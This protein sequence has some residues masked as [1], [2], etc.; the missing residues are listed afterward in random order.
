MISLFLAI[1][2]VIVLVPFSV[3]G[4]ASPANGD[5]G[6]VRVSGSTTLLSLIQEASV[7]FNE[8]NPDVR[9]DVQGG[10]SSAGIT[11]LR[12]GIVDI[13]NSSRDLGE[14]ELSEGFV[15]H[16][17][18]FDIIQVV[19]NPANPVSNLSPEQLRRIYTG[20]IRNWRAVGGRN[21][22]IVLIVRD[23]A[24][25]T[26]EVFDEEGLG[27]T[28]DK[29]VIS[30]ASAIEGTSNGFVQEVV[31]TT[32]NAI[33]YLSF[34]FS[35][36]GSGVKTLKIDGVEPSIKNAL[37]GDYGVA[38]WLYM[39]TKGEATGPTADFIDFV[40][41]EAFQQDVLSQEYVTI[42]EAEGR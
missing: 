34:G 17:I 12:S 24:S 22:E 15:G 7:R 36:K 11:Q 38:R 14:N 23:H 35:K 32:P 9:V 16:N 10:G 26:R 3:H 39:F 25:G 42:G 2:L 28:A 27:S 19:V 40:A 13:A 30:F 31:R 8:A 5:S 41:S 18:A 21:E 20:E 37:S 4:G 6:R 29:P 1:A 33:G